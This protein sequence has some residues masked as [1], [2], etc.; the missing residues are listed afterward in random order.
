MSNILIKQ[1]NMSEV[2]M[3]NAM[4]IS[5]QSVYSVLLFKPK[6][7]TQVHESDFQLNARA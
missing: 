7:E 4:I 6:N 3:L 2:E 5:R 1:I